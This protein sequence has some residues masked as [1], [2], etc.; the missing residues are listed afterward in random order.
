[1]VR[2][3]IIN[4]SIECITPKYLVKLNYKYFLVP[5]IANAYI[6]IDTIK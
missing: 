6:G 5:S 3:L 1:M 2:F 4:Q